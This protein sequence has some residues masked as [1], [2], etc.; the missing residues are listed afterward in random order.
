MPVNL[1]AL[2]RR[3]GMD[4]SLFEEMVDA[5]RRLGTIEAEMHEILARG[6]FV[7]KTISHSTLSSYDFLT[8]YE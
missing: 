7:G 1:G 4:N 3:K 8:L 5:V 6:F 2:S